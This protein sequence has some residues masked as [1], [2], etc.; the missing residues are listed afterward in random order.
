[1]KMTDAF[2]GK[3]LKKEDFASERTLTIKGCEKFNVAMEN[4]PDEYKPGLTFEEEP[5][6]L[7]LNKTNWTLIAGF[8]KSDDTDDWIGKKVTFYNDS[9]VQMKGKVIGGVRAKPA[10]QA[11]APF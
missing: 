4:Q 8:L 7:I 3:F 2:P 1:M 5:R 9:S 6:P 10:D 11:G